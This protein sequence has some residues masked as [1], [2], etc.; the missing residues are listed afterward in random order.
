MV[1]TFTMGDRDLYRLALAVLLG[2]GQVIPFDPKRR[3]LANE[4]EVAVAD[5][6]SGEKARFGEDLEAVADAEDKFA[7]GSMVTGGPQS[8]G[9]AGDRTTAQIVAIAKTTG[10]DDDI[11]VAQ[12]TVLVPDHA[13]GLA[14]EALGHPEDIAIAVR[15]R[16]D[17]NP[18]FEASARHLG[19]LQ[20]KAVVFD[21]GVGK[22]LVTHLVQLLLGGVFA[23]S[24]QAELD[25]L[26]NADPSD[27]VVA[28]VFE[29]G[30]YGSACGVQ[31]GGAEGD[32]DSSFVGT[33][34]RVL[35]R[36]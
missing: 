27:I 24:A 8:R 35:G 13:G 2:P 1:A 36:S 18:K 30:F 3:G 11:E 6:G 12:V 4:V 19:S 23:G 33:H 7:L 28:E 21:N 9:K 29:A 15:S 10:D 17:D 32:V 34:G 22:E 5:E 31:D 14:E 26:A 16:E 20:L 25:I